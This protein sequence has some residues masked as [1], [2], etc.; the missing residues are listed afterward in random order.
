M[1]IRIKENSIRLRLTK[2][3]VDLFLSEGYYSQN[4][5]IGTV[6]LRYT[7]KSSDD[8]DNLIATFDNNEITV[9]MPSSFLSEWN[10]PTKIG[11]THSINLDKESS[12]LIKVE[13]DFACLDKTDEDQ[14]D[15]YPNP[16]A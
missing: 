7:L 1:K 10:V 14:S 5:R 8:I 3:E 4:C 11:F 16:K 9:S 12:L 13:K 15:N 6:S 2:S